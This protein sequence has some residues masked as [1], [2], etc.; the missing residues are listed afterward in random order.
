MNLLSLQQKQAVVTLLNQGLSAQK[1]SEQTG[2]SLATVYRLKRLTEK[3]ISPSD[4][5][6]VRD[7][8]ALI[9]WVQ[10]PENSK[11]NN[12]LLAKEWLIATGEV[13]S[14]PTIGKYKRIIIV[15]KDEPLSIDKVVQTIKQLDPTRN[16]TT[17]IDRIKDCQELGIRFIDE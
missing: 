7:R 13:V 4:C 15:S 2:V 11:K 17:L 10:Y 8:K 16:P 6:R 5:V 3:G 1:A 12:T 14:P 9:E